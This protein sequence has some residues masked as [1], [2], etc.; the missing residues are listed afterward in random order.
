MM[1]EQ[2]ESREQWY[3]NAIIERIKKDSA[4]AAAL[5]KADNPST[6]YLAW[7]YLA[8]YKVDLENS[9]ERVPYVTVSAALA[10]AK[11]AA[12][13]FLNIGQAIARSGKDGIPSDQERARLR[14]VLACETTVEL[15]PILR[16]LLNLIQSRD[17]KISYGQ[18]LSDLCWFDKNPQKTKARWAQSFFRNTEAD[19]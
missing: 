8:D 6:E 11:P 2:K 18:L 4:M 16:P 10:R 15:C 3:V 9:R 19:E 17:I 5:K 14:R 1:P 12:D 7:E 13:G